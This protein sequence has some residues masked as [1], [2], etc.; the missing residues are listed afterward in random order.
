MVRALHR[1]RSHSFT[2]TASMK[3]FAATPM[4]EAYAPCVVALRQIRT[5]AK[6]K[7]AR[8]YHAGRLERGWDTCGENLVCPPTACTRSSFLWSGDVQCSHTGSPRTAQTKY[9]SSWPGR[10][11]QIP[12]VETEEGFSQGLN[13]GKLRKAYSSRRPLAHTRRNATLT[14]ARRLREQPSSTNALGAPEGREWRGTG[15]YI[16]KWTHRFFRCILQE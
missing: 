4:L 7:E 11:F 1:S 6:A 15:K 10:A 5:A 16:Y 12:G 3:A 13:S 2:F 8:M 14:S 9:R